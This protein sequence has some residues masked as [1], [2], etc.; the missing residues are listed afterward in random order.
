MEKVD[1]VVIGAGV[2]GLAIAREL[3]LNGREVIIVE[4]EKMI[5]S[6]T[7][8]RNSGVIHAG[9][10]Y[11]QGSSKARY[12]VRGRELLY[13]YTGRRNIPFKKC[14]K[15]IVATYDSEKEKL[16]EIQCNAEKNNV[17]DLRL[18]TADEAQHIEPQLSCVAALHSPSTGIID[19]HAYL[20]ALLTDCEMA[21]GILALQNTVTSGEVTN[22][23]TILEFDDPAQT[24]I[25]ASIVVNAAGTQ[26]QSIAKKLKGF[27]KHTIPPQYLA[28]GNYFSIS[29]PMPFSQL[30]YPVPV[31]GGLGA[32]F[33][34]NMANNSLFGP[35]VEWLDSDDQKNINYTV[36]ESR[37]KN[38]YD[39]VRRYWPNVDNHELM[40]AY[41]GIRS[42]LSKQGEPDSDFLIH[43][44]Q[45]HGVSGL[46]NLYGIES[47]GITSSL[48]IAEDVTEKLLKLQK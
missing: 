22:N 1:A 40:P 11:K 5:G 16:K 36:D 42:K 3:S 17:N 45:H 25:I 20:L 12:C 33:T 7:S 39:S 38:F 8:A 46:V 13:L 35:D 30:I 23:G 14:G 48:A 37:S 15:L 18:I 44:Q 21:G 9:I 10:Y 32:H 31:P 19:V 4:S 29:G 43:T 47:P 28:K 26:S 27:P 2:I 6:V 41:A 24:R 34:M